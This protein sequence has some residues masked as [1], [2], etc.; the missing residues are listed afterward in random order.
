M[1]KKIK[2]LSAMVVMTCGWDMYAGQNNKLNVIN[3]SSMFIDVYVANRNTNRETTIYN[4]NAGI[5]DSTNRSTDKDNKIHEILSKL[6]NVAPNNVTTITYPQ[7]PRGVVV[8]FYDPADTT[9][10]LNI[11]TLPLTDKNAQIIV[12]GNNSTGDILTDWST[13]VGADNTRKP[14]ANSVHLFVGDSKTSKA[15]YYDQ[16]KVASTKITTVPAAK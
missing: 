15:A 4:S 2:V 11:V 6:S 16:Q 3:N 1:F 13:N 10:I 9:K 8:R 5:D 14:V 12:E 7:D